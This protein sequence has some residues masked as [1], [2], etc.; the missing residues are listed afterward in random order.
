VELTLFLDHDCNLRCSYC[1]GGR[2]F[3]RPM[4]V[5][6][7]ER[8]VDL[9]LSDGPDDL[10]IS[11][12]GGEPLLHLD[13]VEATVAYAE[14]AARRGP[15]STRLCFG[16]NTNGT[17]I[18][19]RVLAVLA[20]PQA[21]ADGGGRRFDTFVSLDGP[22]SVHDPHRSG[23]H[24]DV[25]AGLASLRRRGIPYTLVA[26]VRPDTA[27][28]LGD[29]LQALLDEQPCAVTLTPDLEAP[30]TEGS[31][32]E[33]RAGLR[34]LGE[35]WTDA[36]RHGRFVPVEPLHTKILSHLHG[37]L[38]CT[39]RCTWAGQ[40]FAV[41]P[42]GRIYPCGQ[43]IG[44]DTRDDLVVGTVETG[45][46]RAKLAELRRQK[47][48]VEETCDPCALRCRCQSYCGCRHWALTGEL[49]RI[50]ATLC[51]IEE[52]FVV[53]GDHV[54]STLQA[55][56]CPSFLAAYYQQRYLQGAGSLL[57]RLRRPH[58]A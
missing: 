34:S 35:V 20:P 30:W 18:D 2:K 4:P 10:G 17:R 47:D 5:E 29:S 51:E 9:A 7:M 11:F 25:V 44:D 53:A 21:V 27:G 54:A 31:V 40:A 38:P 41:A 24:P 12:F 56:A 48:R 15:R 26:V 52:A 32:A 37:C 50:N 39:A 16:M 58:K 6:T 36:F 43:M 33:L 28:R 19:E 13:L 1:Y 42:S 49:G 8:A 3:S 46:S 22:P 14:A 45:L 23:S 55:E 57:T